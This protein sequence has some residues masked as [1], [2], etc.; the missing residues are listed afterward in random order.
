MLPGLGPR[1]GK[2][3]PISGIPVLSGGGNRPICLFSSGGNSPRRQVILS[4]S[5]QNHNSVVLH[6]RRLFPTDLADAGDSPRHRVGSAW[7]TTALAAKG[8]HQLGGAPAP[9]ESVMKPP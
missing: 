8:R 9:L 3:G 5:V 2:Q 6:D 7:S 4:E 1:A